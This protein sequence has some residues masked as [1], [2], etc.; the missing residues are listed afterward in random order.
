MPRGARTNAVLPRP[1]AVAI[2]LLSPAAAVY[3]STL[4]KL[5]MPGRVTTSHAELEDDCG[6][7]HAPLTDVRQ[8]SLCLACHEAVADDL[9]RRRG[10]HGR[11]RTARVAE[12]ATCHTDHAGRDADIV[13]FNVSTFNHRLTDFLLAGAHLGA[14]CDQCH[15]PETA[16]SAAPDSCLGCHAQ[17]DHHNGA[18]GAACESCHSDR[19]WTETHF[20]HD[21]T[22]FPLLGAHQRAACAG[23][24]GEQ[25]YAATPDQCVSC[26]GGDD[27]HKG[28]NGPACED[29]HNAES[30][31]ATAFDH[32]SV[33]GFGLAGGHAGL[34]CQACHGAV[35][36]TSLGGADCNSC[37]QDDDVHLGHNGSDCA[38]CHAVSRWGTVSFDHAATTGFV[39]GGA[40]GQLGC[41]SCH[42]GPLE[43]PV[44]TGCAGCHGGDDA[45]LG[46][47]DRRCESC[48]GE[49]SWTAG[50][51]FDH[52]LSVFPLLGRHAELACES[53][54]ASAAFHDAG[55]EC[56]A[57]HTQQDV[58]DGQLGVN[59]GLCH[60]P[61]AWSATRFNHDS[62]TDFA[63]TG[64]H[65]SA[66]CESCHRV[67]ATAAAAPSA[68]GGCHRRD[69]K[70]SG[71][72]GEDCARCHT[73]RSFIEVT[74][75]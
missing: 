14:S 27:V 38:G 63:L 13:Q 39:L 53:C 30:W 65:V 11:D 33:T 34:T 10:F 29:C 58:H 66:S 41:T 4:E 37:H 31:S 23:C 46:Q 28:L 70:H 42:R 36:L 22:G 54:H 47:L 52:D 8:A 44:P 51:T 62:Q 56:A 9:A 43:Q 25:S 2:L 61:G 69:D 7:C 68:C 20:E 12:C 35:K 24:H 74:G 16:W 67:A 26:H 3:G 19:N 32:L 5:V 75:L 40:H 15:R 17:D 1:F 6:L 18:L 55:D 48:H 57:C 64:A 71:R 59:C 50:V 49:N 60:N 45:H 21:N 73:T 72:F